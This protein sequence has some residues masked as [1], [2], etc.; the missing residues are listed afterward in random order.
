MRYP[1]AVFCVRVTRNRRLFP[2]DSGS[3]LLKTIALREHTASRHCLI[4]HLY[5]YRGQSPVSLTDVSICNT[6]PVEHVY[7]YSQERGHP[8]SI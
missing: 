6:L 8:D 3:C 2:S 1:A 5:G 7:S 4:L